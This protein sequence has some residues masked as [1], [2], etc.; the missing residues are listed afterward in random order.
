[1]ERKLFLR[2]LFKCGNPF[3]TGNIFTD[4]DSFIY[5]CFSSDFTLLFFFFLV[6]VLVF[7]FFGAVVFTSLFRADTAYPFPSK[8][9]LFQTLCVLPPPGVL[10]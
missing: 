6:G 3:H 9:K 8:K 5:K 1:M 2:G 7:F 10:Q 4:P